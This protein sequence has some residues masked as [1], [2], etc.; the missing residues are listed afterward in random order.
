[1][2]FGIKTWF[3]DAVFRMKISFGELT[4]EFNIGFSAVI[5]VIGYEQVERVRS[6]CKAR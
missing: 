5:N 4:S 3:S 1:M 6:L 2:S